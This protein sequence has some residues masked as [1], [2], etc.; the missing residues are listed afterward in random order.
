MVLRFLERSTL[1]LLLYLVTFSILLTEDVALE[2]ALLWGAV[3]STTKF[4]AVLLHRWAWLALKS[5][6]GI[7][8]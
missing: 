6:L 3:A 1:W 4:F 8:V 5:S 7:P 2:R